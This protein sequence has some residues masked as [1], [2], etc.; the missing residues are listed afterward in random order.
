MSRFDRILE[1]SSASFPRN[2]R[3]EE[4][5]NGETMHGYALSRYIGLQLYL[6]GTLVNRYVGEDWGW[7]CEIQ[8]KD[9][10]LAYGVVAEDDSQDFLI[11]FI[12]HK[13]YVRK[14]FRKIDVSEPLAQL[15]DDVFAILQSAPLTKPPTWAGG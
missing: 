8:H 6:R 9:F 1:F 15:Q 7:Y 12:P 11:Q 2:A 13:P 3:D 5:A 4:L 10:A 14:L